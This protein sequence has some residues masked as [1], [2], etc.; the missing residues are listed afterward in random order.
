MEELR[1]LSDE[2]ARPALK[3]HALIRLARSARNLGEPE[4]ARRLV[5]E[6]LRL[7]EQHR[8]HVP[9]ADVSRS[10]PLLA[11]TEAEL[12]NLAE[13]ARPAGEVCHTPPRTEGTLAAESFWVAATIHTR[14]GR[15]QTTPP[16]IDEAA[17]W[18]D[19]VRSALD[20]VG[21]PPHRHEFHFPHAQL[22]Y[23]RGDLTGSARIPC[24]VSSTPARVPRAPW[25][26][27]G[28]RPKRCGRPACRTWP[29][30]SG[31]RWR[32]RR[33]RPA[34]HGAFRAPSSS[35][36][37]PSVSRSASG[38]VFGSKVHCMMS[39]DITTM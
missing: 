38:A 34:G 19:A 11:S 3:V 7:S 21:S 37:R 8:L 30:R 18:L 9:S 4:T 25:T 15:L 36:R 28:S 2:L 32:S 20:L 5:G 29:S 10:K 27:C 1:R 17:S 24:A 14:L 23:Y 13:A 22:H 16:R 33:R 39:P 31:G 35:W 6:A 26:G 12:G